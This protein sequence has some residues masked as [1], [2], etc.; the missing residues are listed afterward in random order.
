MNNLKSLLYSLLNESRMH[1]TLD[2]KLL[3]AVSSICSRNRSTNAEFIKPLTKWDKDMLLNRYVAALIV[4]KKPCPQSPE[5]IEKIGTFKLVGQK[6]LQ[7]GATIE[8]INDLYDKNT[9]D[10]WRQ[11]HNISFERNKP[12]KYPVL[13][14]TPDQVPRQKTDPMEIVEEFIKDIPEDM[15]SYID[16]YR[17]QNELEELETYKLAIPHIM[18]YINQ[19]TKLAN[20]NFNKFAK[21]IK[22][23]FKPLYKIISPKNKTYI[24]CD[25]ILRWYYVHYMDIIME[26]SEDN[27]DL[28]LAVYWESTGGIERVSPIDL[29]KN[30]ILKDLKNPTIKWK[31]ENKWYEDTV[32]DFDKSICGYIYKNL[33]I[34]YVKWKVEKKNFSPTYK[35]TLKKYNIIESEEGDFNWFK[36]NIKKIL[37]NNPNKV[38]NVR[39][40][41]WQGQI[42]RIYYDSKKKKYCMDLTPANDDTDGWAFE[43]LD[44]I[45]RCTTNKGYHYNS[46]DDLYVS[47]I[48][49]DEFAK[50]VYNMILKLIKYGKLK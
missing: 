49:L 18:E 43:S 37:F 31:Y 5:D 36:N 27:V 13:D 8:D 42:D 22:K 32:K 4:M 35:S 34:P 2:R 45:L 46:Y 1:E 28:Y 26:I 11:K 16:N 30:N 24:Y 44:D 38:L 48:Y 19:Q 21:L 17:Y 10:T 39:Y 14:T 23:D 25:R 41:D 47:V 40:C 3:L 12:E 29:T 20:Y 6:A 33:V 50:K 15:Y 9:T 7:L